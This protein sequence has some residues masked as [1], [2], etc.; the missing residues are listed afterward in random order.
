MKEL[1]SF[2]GSYRTFYRCKKDISFILRNLEQL[3]SNKPS[4]QKLPWT[5]ELIQNFERA[6][7]EIVKLDKIYLPKAD[8]QLVLTSDY[9]KLGIS[10]TLW[11]SVDNK[12]LVVARMST[13]LEKAQENLKP[14]EGEAIACYVAARCPFFNS[15][16]LASN[17]KTIALLDN[18]PV[19]QAANLLEQ[20][21]FSSSKIINIVLTAIAEL[22]MT[23]HH[24][25]GKLGQNFADDHGSRNPIL[26]KDRK[27]CK[28]CSF[29]DDCS[30]LMVSK[31]SF[32][33]AD[34]R[35]LIG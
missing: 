22:N 18:K 29:V 25:S 12:Y 33:V 26:C 9:S 10:A 1:R 17:K 20:G 15:Y 8:D 24:M 28:I 13:G 32:W 3:T 27:I 5:D 35:M 11:A 31:I 6:K 7:Q 30:Q 19:V 16:I 2:L 34:D 4:S 23:F 14:C 21:K